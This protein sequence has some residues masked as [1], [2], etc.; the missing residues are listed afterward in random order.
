MPVGVHNKHTIPK[1]LLWVDLEMTGLETVDRIIEVAAI[2]TDFEFKEFDQYE[3]AIQQDAAFV[4][5]RFAASSFW[6][7]LP[8]ES[9]A[10]M[11]SMQHGKSED[12]VQDEVCAIID[13][14]FTA[15][16]GVFL[17]GNSIRADRDFIDRW[18]PKVADKLHYRMLEVSSFK[19]WWLGSGHDPFVKQEKHR[20]LED[21]RESIAELQHYLGLIKN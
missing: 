3:T 9:E 12:V 21:I 4:K 20:A 8:V 11:A 5:Q 18:W 10:I 2:V 19:L 6:S 7:K 16:E 14:H 17:A 13:K 15:D 1:K